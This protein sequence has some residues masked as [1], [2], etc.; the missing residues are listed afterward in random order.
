[1]PRHERRRHRQPIHHG[2]N[3]IARGGTEDEVPR[4]EIVVLIDAHQQVPL[5]HP[6]VIVHEEVDHIARDF[7]RQDDDITVGVG[8]VR[9]NL[10]TMRE[11]IDKGDDAGDR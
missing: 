8:V 3:L 6:G 11:P 2:V 5:A 1:M 9:G 4:G 10:V 7:G